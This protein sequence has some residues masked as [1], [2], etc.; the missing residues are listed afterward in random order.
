MKNLKA[1]GTIYSSLLKGRDKYCC[2]SDTSLKRAGLFLALHPYKNIVEAV[3]YA[4]SSDECE[5]ISLE[6]GGREL[7]F[8]YFDGCTGATSIE[9]FNKNGIRVYSYFYGAE[10]GY[11]YEK[12]YDPITGALIDST[13]LGDY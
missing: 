7:S 1:L 4:L 11:G 3:C 12:T 10:Q 6:D 13:E 5:N 9:T 8:S 2:L